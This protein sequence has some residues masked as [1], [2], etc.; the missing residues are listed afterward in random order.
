[1][2]WENVTV[3]CALLV[4]CFWFSPCYADTTTTV[5]TV[6]KQ[7]MILVSRSKLI[8]LRN[9]L[10]EQERKIDQLSIMLTMPKEELKKQEQLIKELKSSLQSA[11]NS[12]SQSELIIAEQNNS[13]R[14]LSQQLK[15]EKAVKERIEQQRIFWQVIAGSIAIY[16]IEQK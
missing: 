13:L 6:Q 1:M 12:L 4:S 7:E 10:I 2:K 3:I 14:I 15:K 11:Q 8:A 16:A 9:L 5:E